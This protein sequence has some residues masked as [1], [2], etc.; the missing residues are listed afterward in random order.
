MKIFTTFIG[1]L[2]LSGCASQI[3][4]SYVGNDVR[5]VM[6]DY[7]TPDNAFD[8]G[9]G[10]RAFQWIMNDNYTTPTTVTTTAN[11]NTYDS[12]SWVNSNTIITGGQTMNSKC[13][14]TMFGRWNED[15]QGWYITDF[16][17]PS[18]MCE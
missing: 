15:R 11:I 5:E 13:I 7:G 3:M 10:R 8:M 9:N 12:N 2:V 1:I 6:V 14:Y 17:K 4:N 16:K 18:L